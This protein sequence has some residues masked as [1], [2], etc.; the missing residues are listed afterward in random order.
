[1][2]RVILTLCVALMAAVAFAQKANKEMKY[3]RSSLYT[4]MVPSDK[5]TGDAK[6]M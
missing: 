5:L 1:M 6:T 3:R 2:R 4:I